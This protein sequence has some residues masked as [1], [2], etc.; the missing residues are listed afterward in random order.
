MSLSRGAILLGQ[1]MPCIKTNASKFKVRK[2]VLDN[3]L[4]MVN[5]GE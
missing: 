4:N 2:M 3:N 5:D 1:C